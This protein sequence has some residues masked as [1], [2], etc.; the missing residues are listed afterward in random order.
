MNVS[1][2]KQ[3]LLA[4]RDELQTRLDKIKADFER[5]LDPDSSERA[6]ELENAEVLN[7]IARITDEELTKVELEIAAL[8]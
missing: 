8:D 6:T 4:R 7:E 5:G 1:E 2:T 3:D